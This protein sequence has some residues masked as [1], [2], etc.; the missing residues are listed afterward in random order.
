MKCFNQ[1]FKVENSPT[2]KKHKP[3]S[4]SLRHHWTLYPHQ[5]SPLYD[6]LRW[7]K[8][9][10]I[11][12]RDLNAKFFVYSV[13]EY[14]LLIVFRK[15]CFIYWGFFHFVKMGRK[16]NY[17]VRINDPSSNKLYCYTCAYILVRNYVR[18][19]TYACSEYMLLRSKAKKKILL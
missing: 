8:D 5:S 10:C 4:P 3:R 9:T 12:S 17:E 13:L 19:M 15:S 7:T 2:A 16:D 6:S 11:I 18:N 14:L 1:I